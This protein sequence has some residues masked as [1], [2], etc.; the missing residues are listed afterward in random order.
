M[1]NKTTK[2]ITSI[3]RNLGKATMYLKRISDTYSDLSPEEVDILKDI[4]GFYFDPKYLK[5]MA[6]DLVAGYSAFKIHFEY[7]K[8]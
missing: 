4:L 5:A 6:N 8:E 1:V 3:K 2:K 7:V